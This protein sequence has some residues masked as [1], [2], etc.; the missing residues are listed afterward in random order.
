[1]RKVT[2]TVILSNPKKVYTDKYINYQTLIP[3]KIHITRKRC[4]NYIERMNLNLRT[5]LKRLNRKTL[6]YSKCV[7]I[8]TACLNPDSYRDT[9]GDRLE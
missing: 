3:H 4:I 1:M 6:C 2:Q 9:F 8:L 5:H 7:L